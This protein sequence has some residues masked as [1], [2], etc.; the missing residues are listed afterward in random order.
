MRRR[1]ARIELPAGRVSVFYEYSQNGAS[2][3][4]ACAESGQ[5]YGCA[6]Y[7]GR[8]H[9]HSVCRSQPKCSVQHWRRRRG[10]HAWLP[11]SHVQPHPTLIDTILHSR[12]AI[13][14]PDDVCCA[15]RAAAHASALSRAR[16]GAPLL[17]QLLKRVFILQHGS[18][19]VPGATC[20]SAEYSR[21]VCTNTADNSSASARL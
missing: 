5:M 7:S 16:C 12:L 8:G 18:L 1:R 20:T 4:G 13:T 17:R 10:A 11:E 19:R 14:P 2:A 9:R 21:S 15:C 6:Q 3:A